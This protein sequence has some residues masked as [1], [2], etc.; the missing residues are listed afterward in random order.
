MPSSKARRR[1]AQQRRG[2]A[3]QAPSRRPPAVARPAE[4]EPASVE[5]AQSLEPVREQAEAERADAGEAVD[6]DGETEADLFEEPARLD[7]ADEQDEPDEDETLE[8]Q[9]ED[10]DEA[11]EELAAEEPAPRGR[12]PRQGAATTVAER[13]RPATRS[14]SRTRR[15]GATPQPQGPALVR[16]FR[17]TFDELRK[18]D[19]P[20][21]SELYRYTII[22]IITVIVLAGFISGLDWVLQQLAQRFVYGASGVAGG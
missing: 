17:E 10:I 20:S 5:E 15:R 12:R 21:P 18:V 6:L 2:A 11:V 9:E 3:A 4:P 16:F 8:E 1:R 7:E 14:T 19:W 13:T 22:V